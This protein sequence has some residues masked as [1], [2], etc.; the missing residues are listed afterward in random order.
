MT[1]LII[2]LLNH[3]NCLLQYPSL[4]SMYLWSEIAW[5]SWYSFSGLFYVISNY[6]K[7]L[8]T[9]LLKFFGSG[10]S[11]AG[12]L[13]RNFGCRMELVWS[14]RMELVW[15]TVVYCITINIYNLYIYQKGLL[16]Y[17]GLKIIQLWPED[18]CYIYFIYHKYIANI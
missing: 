14:C 18:H 11:S 8:G 12:F 6:L 7:N 5:I 15:S 16:S 2:N 9:L 17:N 3:T 10:Q 13:T 1:L 4:F